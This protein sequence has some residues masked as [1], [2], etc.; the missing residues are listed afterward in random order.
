VTELLAGTG[1][2]RGFFFWVLTEVEFMFTRKA[3]AMNT[4]SI[5]QTAAQASRNKFMISF[6]VNI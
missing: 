1:F 3:N 2:A 6:D 5:I 4:S